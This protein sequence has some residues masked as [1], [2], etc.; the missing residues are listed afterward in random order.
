MKV[1][2]RTSLHNGSAQ[3]M[4]VII[5]SFMRRPLG[6]VFYWRPFTRVT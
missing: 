3:P 5:M 1:V 2:G 6:A 4:R